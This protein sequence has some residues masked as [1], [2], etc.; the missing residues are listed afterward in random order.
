MVHRSHAKFIEGR[1][2]SRENTSHDFGQSC[3]V[4]VCLILLALVP[5]NSLRA[6]KVFYT[7][8]TLDVGYISKHYLAG[9]AR[10]IGNRWIIYPYSIRFY[11]WVQAFIF[12]VF[13]LGS[14]CLPFE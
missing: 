11:H 13:T 3:T 9:L 5:L 8:G 2:T 12:I 1:N 4:P 10:I 7:L 6:E 14:E